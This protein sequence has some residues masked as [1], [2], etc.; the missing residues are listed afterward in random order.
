MKRYIGLVFNCL[1][2]LSAPVLIHSGVVLIIE[3]LESGGFI[4][5]M[6]A[7][8]TLAGCCLVLVAFFILIHD[9]V[10]PGIRRMLSRNPRAPDS[11]PWT[12]RNTP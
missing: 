4:P 3:K 10:L 2:G 7:I 12:R 11:A 9:T 5:I 8:T 1:L 6:G